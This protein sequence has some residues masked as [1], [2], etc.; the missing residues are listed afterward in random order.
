[1]RIKYD[2][3]S[4]RSIKI[5]IIEKTFALHKSAQKKRKREKEKK[6]EKALDELYLII[7]KLKIS[8]NDDFFYPGRYLNSNIRRSNEG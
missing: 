7:L 8:K 3:T 4:Q 5:I 6:K 2:R 1:M